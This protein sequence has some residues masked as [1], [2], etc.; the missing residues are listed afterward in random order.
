MHR[1]T[2]RAISNLQ[3]WAWVVGSG[4]LNEQV[5]VERDDEIGDLSRTFNL[6]TAN[7]KN[8]T[9]S[10]DELEMEM[11]YR[12][13]AE[14]ELKIANENLQEQAATTPAVRTEA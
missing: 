7:L 5:P 12:R 9:T 13:E 8:V 3:S 4:E 11:T 14:E 10:R 1:R 2:L 6:M